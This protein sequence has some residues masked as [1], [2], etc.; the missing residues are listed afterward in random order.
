MLMMISLLN[1]WLL[2]WQ[3][4]WFDCLLQVYNQYFIDKIKVIR[5][6]RTCC[7]YKSNKELMRK[8]IE[9][10]W[11]NDSQSV[12]SDLN[13]VTRLALQI[14]V[15]DEL[16]SI[17]ECFFS[18]FINSFCFIDHLLN[19]SICLFLAQSLLSFRTYKNTCTS[20]ILWA[21]FSFPYIIIKISV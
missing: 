9:M 8:V 21:Y 17:I 6:E 1:C 20:N 7:T 4:V 3:W 13:N 2:S 5:I 10:R 19:S 16:L 12:A 18:F 15:N 11:Y 14:S